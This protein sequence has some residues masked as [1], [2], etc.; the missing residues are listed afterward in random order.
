MKKLLI[1]LLI[2]FSFAGVVNFTSSVEHMK[3]VNG[4]AGLKLLAKAS[5]RLTEIIPIIYKED[6]LTQIIYG[7]YFG[8]GVS[9]QYTA[10]R[11][12]Q[13]GYNHYGHRLDFSIGAILNDIDLIYTHSVRSKYSGANPDVIFFNSDIDSIKLRFSKEI[14]F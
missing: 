2:S 7:S 14:K 8:V 13:F 12:S 1:I 6:L 5:M 4:D 3:I 9:Q 10:S 11:S